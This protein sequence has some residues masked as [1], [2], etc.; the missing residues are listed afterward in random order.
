MGVICMPS[1]LFCAP[2]TYSKTNRYLLGLLS[3]LYPPVTLTDLLVPLYDRSWVRQPCSEPKPVPAG[4]C[5][6]GAGRQDR[7]RS[8]PRAGAELGGLPRALRGAAPAG[9]LGQGFNP[10]CSLVSGTA[11]GNGALWLRHLNLHAA[12]SSILTCV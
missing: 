4:A 11:S 2:T 9:A 12:T 8:R 1:V 5:A 10:S 3:L 6:G 7:L